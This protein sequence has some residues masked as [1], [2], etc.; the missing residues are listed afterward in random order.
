M[1]TL[2]PCICMPSIRCPVLAIHGDRDTY[3]PCEVAK[4]YAT[5]NSMS[6]FPAGPGAEHGIRKPE[7]RRFVIP[8][9]IELIEQPML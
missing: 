2:E 7:E 6:R 5:C 3:V 1:E 8:R 4:R 9:T